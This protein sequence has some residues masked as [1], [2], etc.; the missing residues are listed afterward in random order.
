MSERDRGFLPPPSSMATRGRGLVIRPFVQGRDE[1]AWISISN[2]FLGHFLSPD[3]TPMSRED[4]EWFEG[5][6]WFDPSG[7]FVAELD[8]KPI[9]IIRIHVDKRRRDQ[10]GTISIELRLDY[11]GSEHERQMLLFCLGNLRTRGV[12]RARMWV[13][14]NMKERI[15]LLEGEGFREVRSFSV[16]RMRLDQLKHGIGECKRVRLRPIELKSRRDL[17]LL[18]FLLNEAFKG[19]F[20]FRPTTVEESEAWLSQPS[21]EF[22]GL[23]AYWDRTPIGYVVLEVD[24]KLLEAGRKVGEVSSIGVL[25]PYRRLGVGTALMLKGLEWLRDRGLEEARLEVDDDNPTKA[26]RLYEKVGFEVE[27]KLLVYERAI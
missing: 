5:S 21:K 23:F 24:K 14:D 8:G 19:Q 22:Y 18:T 17:E 6:P 16:M 12:R 1:E 26:I 15:E 20:G 2:E 25:R 10:Y 13:R 11:V 27:R 9:G 4:L 3:Y 7:L